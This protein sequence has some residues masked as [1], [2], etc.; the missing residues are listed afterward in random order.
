ME[1]VRDY[2]ALSAAITACLRA[3]VET[4]CA[5]SAAALG[6][7]IAAGTLLAHR[8][9]GGLLLLRRRR[10]HDIV[11]FYRTGPAPLDIRLPRPAV[12]ELP[13][14]PGGAADTAFWK[15]MG[16]RP[17]LERVRLARPALTPGQGCPMT[18]EIPPITAAEALL[19]L[20]ECFDPLTGCL[21]ALEEL[22]EDLG[23]NRLLTEGGLGLL[24]FE[25]GR[26]AKIR[27]LAV[28]PE[29]RGQGMAHRLVARFNERTGDRRALVWTGAENT[30]ARRVY[31][32][33]GFVSDGWRSLVLAADC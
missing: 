11:S 21:P 9:A 12:V 28:A 19:L 15:D 33:A 23:E 24:R 6:R 2:G 8:W 31:E 22:E 18:L 14:R 17:L 29:A 3:G 10:G 5:L 30:A 20:E 16:F 25:D 32:N 26:T 13:L 1:I 4:N 27:H 7:E